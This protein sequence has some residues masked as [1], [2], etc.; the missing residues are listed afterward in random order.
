MALR[1]QE[2]RVRHPNFLIFR[3]CRSQGLFLGPGRGEIPSTTKLEKSDETRMRPDR[4]LSRSGCLGFSVR[5]GNVP[6][7]PEFPVPEFPEFPN[8]CP[9]I[10]WTIT[11][12]S[13]KISLS[14]ST[15]SSTNV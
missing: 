10:P 9:R 5:L 7:V 15:G 13:N 14:T 8:S 4:R 3:G 12:G 11:A 1:D 6:S 2:W